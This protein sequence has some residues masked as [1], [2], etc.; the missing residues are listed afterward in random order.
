MI[1]KFN[2]RTHKIILQGLFCLPIL[3]NLS[4]ADEKHHKYQDDEEVVLWMNTV[5]PY[6]NR[7][8][9]YDYYSLPFCKG[10]STKKHVR[11]HENIGDA[12]QGIEF[13]F[14]GLD[15]KFKKNV[16]ATEYCKIN[17]HEGN[18]EE[19][20][21][22]INHHYWYQAYIDDLPI[23][24]IVGEIAD[25]K[26]YMIWTH[27]KFEIG[28]NKDRIV[29][30]NLI[31]E[32]K[33]L[34]KPRKEITFSYEVVW[35]E[36]DIEYKH[37][38]EKYLDPTFFQHRIHW[39]SI[40]N[41]FMMV[42]FLVGLVS[43][44]LIRTLKKDYARYK[45]EDESAISDI[46]RDLGD[47]YGW[48][49]IHGDVFRCASY[50]SL[51]SALVSSG[52]HLFF[53]LIAVVTLAV[54]NDIWIDH[55]EVVTYG[56]FCYVFLAPANGYLGGAMFCRMS[57]QAN[58]ISHDPNTAAEKKR[59]EKKSKNSTGIEINSN[60]SSKT[61][62]KSRTLHWT[63]QMI[64]SLVLVPVF[65]WIQGTII[66]TT[67]LYYHTSRAVPLLTILEL[68]GIEGLIVLPLHIL[69]TIVG[70]QVSGRVEYPC[71]VNVQK[72]PIPTKRWYVKPLIIIILAGLLPFGSIFIEMYFVFTSFWAYKIYYVY[73]FMLLVSLILATVTV[74]V[75]IVCT[76]FLL[77]SED[78]RW[79]WTS[80]FSAAST[81]GYVYVYSIYYF[82]FKTKMYG[83]YQTVFYFT[84]MGLFCMMLGIMCGALGYAGSALFVRKIYANVKI[85]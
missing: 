4:K 68:V 41:S 73:G 30:V 58:S 35:T 20:V 84:Y 38:F 50:P 14:S 3:F 28:Y 67:S 5:G 82:I 76:Y 11:P 42:I 34:L 23:W 1:L 54:T 49:Q 22:A 24:G 31:S 53:T 81:A 85:D 83:I 72:R 8:E 63:N 47:E 10:T 2:N 60:A 56:L 7:Q 64:L 6:H 9:T 52:W 55:G 12:L 37:R 61:A 71:R 70:R 44:I 74:C 46:E 62:A 25:D 48:K 29:D 45:H 59:R 36:S 17:L 16:E 69:G 77:N 80:F 18:Y 33:E 19:M 39:F 51:L 43:M 65:I 75:N 27:K 15:I 79:Q 78:Y 57:N 26:N 13:V 32:N 40:F 21:H 66:E